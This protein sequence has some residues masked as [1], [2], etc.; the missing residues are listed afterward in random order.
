MDNYLLELFW[1]YRMVGLYD[2]LA[3][4]NQNSTTVSGAAAP[5]A[6]QDNNTHETVKNSPSFAE[7][8]K[9]ASEKYGVKEEV[10]SAVIKQESGFDADI[11][12]RCGAQ[13]LM[14]LMPRT[15]AALGV[16]DAFNPEENIMA[17]TKYLKQ[18]LDEFG[19]NLEM[20]LAAYNAGSGAVRKYHGIPPYKETKA[21]VSRIINNIER[22]V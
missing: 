3:R 19:G 18:K 14:Q 15:A 6:N 1:Q 21:Y 10:I 8:I 9:K 7:I 16:K 13:G 20:A 2:A 5:A 12:S 22:S 11:V 17:G 4:Q